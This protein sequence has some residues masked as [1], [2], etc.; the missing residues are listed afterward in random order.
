MI[1]HEFI[2]LLGM[3]EDVLLK[4]K[5]RIWYPKVTRKVFYLPRSFDY[6][7]PSVASALI[8]NDKPIGNVTKIRTGTNYL[9]F[10]YIITSKLLS[11]FI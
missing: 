2:E 4:I 3:A 11:L 8:L 10:T 9:N 1:A 5:R 6:S 7:F